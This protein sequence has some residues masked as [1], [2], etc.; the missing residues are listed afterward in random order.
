MGR[1][2][3]SSLLAAVKLRF[4]CWS[5]ISGSRVVLRD[6]CCFFEKTASSTAELDAELP[7]D[8]RLTASSACSICLASIVGCKRVSLIPSGSSCTVPVFCY[9]AVLDFSTCRVISLGVAGKLLLSRVSSRACECWMLFPRVL[10][11]ALLLALSSTDCRL[12]CGMLVHRCSASLRRAVFG[13]SDAL[14]IVY[15]SLSRCTSPTR[16]PP[17]RSPSDRPSSVLWS[18]SPPF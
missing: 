16:S 1:E 7:V 18:I 15:L 4:P 6:Y 10:L 11:S 14:E 3:T 12:R 5:P 8:L 2:P 13:S 17:W 9:F